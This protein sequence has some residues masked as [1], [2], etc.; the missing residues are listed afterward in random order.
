MAINNQSINI[1][2]SELKV[3]RISFTMTL[4]KINPRGREGEVGNG[5]DF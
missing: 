5:D 4:L 1:Y 2:I 3:T